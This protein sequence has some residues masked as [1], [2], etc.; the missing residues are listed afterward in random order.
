MARVC[1]GVEGGGGGPREAFIPPGE[2]GPEGAPAGELT[3]VACWIRI[4][5]TVM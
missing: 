1:L 5:K 3:G 4:R 2:N